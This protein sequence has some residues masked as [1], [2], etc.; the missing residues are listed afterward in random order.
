[1]TRAALCPD[2]VDDPVVCLGFEVRAVALLAEMHLQRHVGGQLAAGTFQQGPEEAD[3]GLRETGCPRG[4][5]ERDEENIGHD[6][7]CSTKQN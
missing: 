6:D 1:M 5:I 2:E 4:G 3:G 7:V